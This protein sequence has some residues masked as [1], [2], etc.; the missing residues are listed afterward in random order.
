M[1][2]FVGEQGENSGSTGSSTR[3]STITDDSMTIPR[4]GGSHGDR[5]HPVPDGTLTTTWTRWTA[6]LAKPPRFHC[7]SS[8]WLLPASSIAREHS[9]YSPGIAS[10]GDDQATQAHGERRSPRSAGRQLAPPSVLTSTLAIGARPDQ[11]RPRSTW[12]PASSRRVRD[13]KSGMPGGS[14][15]ERG[16]IRVTGTPGSSSEDCSR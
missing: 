5:G 10:H 8:G 12:R 14:S 6:L 13:R 9:T 4:Y 7:R 11:A 2:L 1:Q 16:S 15:S 3:A